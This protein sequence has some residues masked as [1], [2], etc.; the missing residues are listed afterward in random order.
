MS[1][2]E[3]S[4]EPCS[5]WGL[6]NRLPP[7]LSQLWKLLAVLGIAGLGAA[8]LWFLPPTSCG[9]CLCVCLCVFSSYKDT[10]YWIRTHHN[11][12]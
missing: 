1:E 4:A 7:C 5:F 8:S 9:H 12:V 10:C 6:Q 11:P 2:I 3:V